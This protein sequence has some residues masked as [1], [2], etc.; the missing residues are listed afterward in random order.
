MRHPLIYSSADEMSRRAMSVIALVVSIVVL[1][2]LVAAIW[3]YYP[4]VRKPWGPS[5]SVEQRIRRICKEADTA[6]PPE[7]PH[8]VISKARRI[9]QL[10][11]GPKLLKE[12]RVGL[13]TNPVDDKRKE[14]DGCTPEGDFYICSRND[15]SRYHLFMGISYPNSE[16]AE[17]G[18]ASKLISENEYRRIVDDIQNKRR[19]PWDTKLGGEIGIHGGGA[20]SDWTQGCVALSNEDIEEI[21]ML[22]DYNT[23]VT[24]THD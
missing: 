10:Y 6:Y 8:I 1:L 5:R 18:K 15:K 9:L 24:I 19:P 7:T 22:L 17:R 13:G 4:F 3:W 23:P 2:T 21:F 16:D 14:G 11:D 20:D 12:C